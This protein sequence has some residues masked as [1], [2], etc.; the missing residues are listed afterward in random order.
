MKK[1][2][3]LVFA[4]VF[5]MGS[6]AC[7][8]EGLSDSSES[9]VISDSI[10]QSASEVSSA[11]KKSFTAEEL[12]ELYESDKDTAKEYEDQKIVVTGTCDYVSVFD[13]IHL[14]CGAISKGV[15]CELEDS[16]D[17]QLDEV[18]SGDIIEV[19]GIL[20]NGFGDI[21]LE[22]CEILNIQKSEADAESTLSSS[23][24]KT[25]PTTKPTA[26]PT[27]APT[28]KPTPKPTVKPTPKPTAKPTKKPTPK[29]TAKPPVSSQ[30]R[31][32]GSIDS[33]KYHYPSCRF[34]EKILPENEIWFDSEED[35]RSQEYVPCGVC[36]P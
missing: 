28:T 36:K 29:P 21:E 22:D 14:D 20:D 4:T 3:M 11:E 23:V 31:Y 25:T 19:E 32:V 30:G 33:D 18:E 27:P 24:E 15:V 8:T 7:S 6:T 35:A 9:S 16:D 1:I 5:C 34:A 13:K 12:A 2:L 26:K 17:P 10:T